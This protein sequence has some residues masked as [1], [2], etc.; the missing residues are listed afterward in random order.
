MKMSPP[1]IEPA[2]LCI[3]VGHLDSLD[4]EAFDNLCI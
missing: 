1:G 3:L 2:T 4:I